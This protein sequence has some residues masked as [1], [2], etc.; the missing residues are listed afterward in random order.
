MNWQ[1]R[2]SNYPIKLDC[3]RRLSDLVIKQAN[4]AWL[5]NQIW[6]QE[7]PDKQ[8]WKKIFN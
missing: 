7:K 1:Q 5:Q 6:I 3:E 4:I 8:R 2:S